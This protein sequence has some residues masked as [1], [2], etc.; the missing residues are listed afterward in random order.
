MKNNIILTESQAAD[1]LS[2]SENT[3]A[4]MAY[5]GQIPHLRISNP[6]GGT[7]Q[8][9]FNSKALLDWINSGPIIKTNNQN[10]VARFKQR[11]CKQYPKTLSMLKSYDK[12]FMPRRKP[13]GY[14]LTKVAN[15]KIGFIYYVRYIDKGRLVP[16]RWSTHTNDFIAATNFAIDNRDRLLNEYYHKKKLN[17]NNGI[18]KIMK[19]YYEKD[20]PYQKNDARRGRTLGED[21]RKQYHGAIINHW[22]PFLRKRRITTLDEINIPLMVLFQDYCMDKGMKPQSVNYIISFIKNIFDYLVLRGHIETNPCKGLIPLSV[23]EEENKIRG[24]YNI[25]EMK[26]IFNK[27]WSD[28]ISFLLC[29]VIYSTGIRNSEIDRIKVKDIIRINQC[30]FI[31]IPKS[32]TK[33]GARMVPLHDFVH[34]KLIRYI[35]Q[36]KKSPEDLL[37]CQKKGKIIPRFWYKDANIALGRYTGYD[38]SRLKKENITFYS[39]RHFWKTMVNADDL[40]DVEEYFMG[41]KVSNDVAKRYNHRDKQGQEKIVIKAKQVFRIL[42]KTLFISAKR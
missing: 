34:G 42:D 14:N 19:Q 8:L 20:S 30:W 33:Y 39:G 4:A 36:H 5:G 18:Y 40:G 15:K 31:N 10:E 27:R 24:C 16:T 28:N 3:V 11:L 2:I 13:K 9:C 17:K 1:I 21:T 6:V 37:F 35:N 12:Q 23:Q 7:P 25:T 32:K 41:H 38:K 22:I 29:L 26:G